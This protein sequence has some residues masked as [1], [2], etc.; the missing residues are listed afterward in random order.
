MNEKVAVSRDV[1]T[2]Y[3]KMGGKIL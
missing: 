1:A 3:I 2:G